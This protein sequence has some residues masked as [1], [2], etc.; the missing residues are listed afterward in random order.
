[1]YETLELQKGAEQ[2]SILGF[3]GLET[4]AGRRSR[5]ERQKSPNTSSSRPKQACRTLVVMHKVQGDVAGDRLFTVATTD[6][7]SIEGL[8]LRADEV[9]YRLLGGQ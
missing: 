5:L 9:R 2:S 6:L 3:G 8:G 4:G 7:G 1:M